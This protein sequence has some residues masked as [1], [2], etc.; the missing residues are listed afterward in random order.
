MA[1][2]LVCQAALA[3]VVCFY[4]FYVAATVLGAH[5]TSPQLCFA[6]EGA[7]VSGML[8]D[9][10]CLQRVAQGL[11]VGTHLLFVHLL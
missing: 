4:C 8:A 7:D 1:T 11:T 6:T 2:L 3:E 10:A 5:I 9:N